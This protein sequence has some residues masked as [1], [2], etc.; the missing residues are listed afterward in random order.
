MS[1][2]LDEFLSSNQTLNDVYNKL[3]ILDI[4]QRHGHTDYID[5]IT[6]SEVKYP[7]MKGTD[8]FRRSFIV[9]KCVIDNRVIMQT[10][11]QRYSDYTSGWMG[12]GHA[13]SFLIDTSGG[14]DQLQFKLIGEL[15]LEKPITIQEHHRP[16][17]I[18]F[19]GKPVY[20]YR[21]Y[22]AANTIKKQWT[23]CRWNPNYQMCKTI[24]YKNYLDIKI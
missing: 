17:F 14:M 15:I 19:I 5:F 12:C 6:L 24:Q 21:L 20:P 18:K 22:L 8:C 16:D 23:L 3:P 13:T 9:I 1:S 7:I 2:R 4:G 10:F 11:F